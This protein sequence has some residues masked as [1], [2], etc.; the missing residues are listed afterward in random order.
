M[1]TIKGA[2]QLLYDVVEVFEDGGIVAGKVGNGG[3]IERGDVR[4]ST[5]DG[6]R[7]DAVRVVGAGTDV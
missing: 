4:L 7:S 3:S 2:E 1:I 6:E 5:S